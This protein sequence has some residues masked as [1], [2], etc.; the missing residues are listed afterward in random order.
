MKV[1]SAACSQ[2]VGE[3]FEVAVNSTIAKCLRVF[4]NEVSSYYDTFFSRKG[5]APIF[6]A[7]CLVIILSH[8]M[9]NAGSLG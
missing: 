6:I 1:I 9:S 5:A 4:K 2:L 7:L 8:V 3:D